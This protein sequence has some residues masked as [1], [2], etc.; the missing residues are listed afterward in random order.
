MSV[1]E[2]SHAHDCGGKFFYLFIY[3]F[4]VGNILKLERIS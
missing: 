2:V 3:T 1:R 4:Q